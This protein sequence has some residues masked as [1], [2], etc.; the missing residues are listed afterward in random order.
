MG[1]LNDSLNVRGHLS[2]DS[3]TIP[4]NTLRNDGIHPDAAITR[5]KFI[6]ESL[7]EFPI[8]MT[9][10]RVWDAIHTDL[11]GTAATDDLALIGGTFGTA[12][13]QIRSFDFKATTTTARARGIVRM[14]A[15]YQAAETV[16]IRLRCGM[17]TTIADASCTVDIECY[18]QDADGGISADLC[19]TAAQSINSLTKANKDFVITAATLLPGDQL[20]IRIT[21]TGTDSAT[22][23][24]VIAAIS[25]L[26][27]LCDIRG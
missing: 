26:S 7:A 11:P 21:V 16:N 15:E 24:A 3:M 23:T 19:T 20:D 27:L 22:A 12:A 10:L 17:V 13:P 18:R 25:K 9:D 5:A 4:D 14:P 6:L 1:M 8:L 2:A